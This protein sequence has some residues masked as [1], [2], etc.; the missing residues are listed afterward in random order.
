M[1]INTNKALTNDTS[2]GAVGGPLPRNALSPPG[3]DYSGILEW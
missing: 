3:A 2:P 1:I